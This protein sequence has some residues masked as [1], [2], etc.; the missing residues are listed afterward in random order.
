MIRP[1]EAAYYFHNDHLG[2]PQLLTNDSQAIAWKAAYTA[3]GQAVP[4]IQT[5]ENPFRFPGQYYDQETGLHYNYH[6]Y[7]DPM[8]GRYVTPDPIGLWGGINLFVY[9]KNNP[10]RFKDPRGLFWCDE[11]GFCIPNPDQ[12]PNNFHPVG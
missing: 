2:T 6:R 11:L 4:S 3:F 9:V 5:V 12:D 7:Y 8:T 10:V 1:G